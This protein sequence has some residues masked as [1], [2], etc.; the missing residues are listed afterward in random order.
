[1]GNTDMMILLFYLIMR[2]KSAGQ[3]NRLHMEGDE[4]M[5]ESV[6]AWVPNLGKWVTSG[7]FH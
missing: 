2:L 4:R 3:G 7:A 5:N 1:M 6:M